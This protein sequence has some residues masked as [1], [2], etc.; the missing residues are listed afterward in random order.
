MWWCGVL[1]ETLV[2]ETRGHSAWSRATHILLEEHIGLVE[3]YFLTY[4]IFLIY[5]YHQ[6][7]SN[8]NIKTILPIFIYIRG[9]HG[10]VEIYSFKNIIL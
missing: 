1:V 8:Q 10:L 9:A 4:N 2:R 5:F 3:I 7:Y 6:M